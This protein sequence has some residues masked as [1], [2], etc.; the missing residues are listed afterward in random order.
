M[1]KMVVCQQYLQ[2]TRGKVDPIRFGASLTP[3]TDRFYHHLWLPIPLNRSFSDLMYY[4]I[5]S[6]SVS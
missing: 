3:A 2:S 4:K 6:L 5:H 1:K